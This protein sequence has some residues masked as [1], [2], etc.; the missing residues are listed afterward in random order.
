MS[1]K[2]GF[3]LWQL[4]VFR[5]IVAVGSL[6][7]G[8]RQVGL[9]Q[10]AASQ[11]VSNLERAMGVA[12]LDREV[13]PVQATTAGRL[14]VERADD[15]LERARQLENAVRSI[16]HNSI[17]VLRIAM[18]S[19]LTTTLGPDFVRELSKSVKRCTL[20]SNQRGVSEQQFQA[21]EIDLL[22]GVDLLKDVETVVTI[23]LL[24]EPFI[25]AVPAEWNLTVRSFAD[26]KGRNFIRHTQRTS[27][28]RQIEHMLR[29]M[30]LDFPR[31]FE[32]ET[33]DTIAAM[34]SA[35][36]GWS[37]TSPLMMLQSKER[38]TGVQLLPL[39]GITMR[40]RIDLYARKAELGTIPQEVA[41]VLHV[42]L[43]DRIAPG[44][45]AIAPWMGSQLQVH[46]QPR[47]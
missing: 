22:I 9:T 7:K 21:R 3:D 43:R 45:Q 23:P 35:G 20:F 34:M 6:T 14:L 37:I 12:L 40:R 1:Q 30:R 13:R 31:E 15:L 27:A 5:T 24:T 25:L 2:L 36:L 8:A 28:G 17:P 47:I 32:S 16:S 19:S 39:P 4:E 11:L 44:L 26:L 42:L 18:V 38:L 29:Q 10:S 33:V 46:E 41:S